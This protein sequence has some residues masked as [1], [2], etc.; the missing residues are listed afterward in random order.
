[1]PSLGFHP[2]TNRVEVVEQRNGP[3]EVCA[4][5]SAQN[6]SAV[7]L[8]QPHAFTD[9]SGRSSVH[10]TT[11][12]GKDGGEVWGLNIRAHY[13]FKEYDTSRDIL[14]VILEGFCN[15]FAQRFE[16]GKVDEDIDIDGL[17]TYKLHNVAR[18]QI[19]PMIRSDRLPVICSIR[20][21]HP[22]C[23]CRGCRGERLYYPFRTI[24]RRRATDVASNARGEFSVIF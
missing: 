19:S 24:T 12:G 14:I 1:M 23:C 13:L 6:D 21:R 22:A 9:Q 11:L 20:L 15:G 18:S 3:D 4:L 17:L 10:C 8:A 2:S 16:T 5:E 7:S